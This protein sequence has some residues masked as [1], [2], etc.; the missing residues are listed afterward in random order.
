MEE[1]WGPRG[2]VISYRRQLEEFHQ[3]PQIWGCRKVYVRFLQREFCK[4]IDSEAVFPEILFQW[5]WM[6]L[7]PVLLEDAP[8]HF[9]GVRV[10]CSIMVLGQLTSYIEKTLSFI[11]TSLLTQK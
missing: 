5:I 11:S 7:E 3:F 9:S 4:N 2:K 8:G 1:H 10:D 6:G